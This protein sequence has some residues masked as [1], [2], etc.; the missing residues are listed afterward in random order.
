[1]LV[2]PKNAAK[3]VKLGKLVMPMNS[4]SNASQV[5]EVIEVVKTVKQVKPWNLLN[6]QSQ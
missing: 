6:Q 1:M 4:A 3:S 2:K 5:I